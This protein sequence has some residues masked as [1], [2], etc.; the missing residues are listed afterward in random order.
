M[1]NIDLLDRIL[2]PDGWFAV[3][4]IKGKK[5]VV[6]ELVQTRAEVDKFA[7][8]FVNEKR[9]VYFGCSKF[10]TS[11]NRTKDNV[12]DIKAFWMDIDCGESKALVNE[13]T[14]RPDGYIDQAT[15]L[16]EL[17][18][19]CKTIGLPRPLLVNSGR[20]IHAYWPLVTPVTREEWEPVAARLNELCVIHKLYVD[21]S[22]FEAARVL[23][24]PGTFNFKDEPPK[25]VEVIA[26]APDVEYQAIKDL[27]GVK[28][29][30]QIRP[31]Q[32][33]SELAK[34]MMSNSTFKFSKIM[35]RSANGEGC[36]QL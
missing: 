28:E 32:E 10:K 20:G 17:Q 7:A 23:R 1:T 22:V 29:V 34:A 6:Q 13:K 19:F 31:T 12:K 5:N 35:M 4:G 27:L 9:E 11:D 36:A 15:G 16:Q 3:L 25:P 24:I 21:A 2:A 14:N 18:K 26:D 33:L 8:K 30:K